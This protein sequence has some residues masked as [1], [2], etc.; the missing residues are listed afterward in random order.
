MSIWKY[1]NCVFAINV[2]DYIYGI[3]WI[4]VEKFAI[5]QSN[6]TSMPV[7]VYS[8]CDIFAVS[9]LEGTVGPKQSEKLIF[10]RF[11]QIFLWLDLILRCIEFRQKLWELIFYNPFL[12][13][14]IHSG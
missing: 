3:H 2:M 1:H 6:R 4:K 5:M 12:F 7:R 8:K 10:A 13:G 14:A 11:S 9:H